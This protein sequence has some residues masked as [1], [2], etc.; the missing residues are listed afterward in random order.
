MASFQKRG[1]SWR[2]IVRKGGA[3]QSATFQTKAAAQA[4]AATTEAGIIAGKSGAIP[5]K[6]FG[7]LLDEY[8]SKVSPTK[9]GCRWEQVRIGLFKRDEIASVKLADLG[10]PHFAAWRDRRLKSVSPAT[11]RREWVLMSG[12]CT[13]AQGMEMAGSSPNGRGE[14]PSRSSAA[15]QAD[16]GPRARYAAAGHGWRLEARDRPNL[17]CVHVRMR[18]GHAC[19]ATGHASTA[20]KKMRV[21]CA[22]ESLYRNAEK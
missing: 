3:A 15:R 13:V 21:E 2:A 17:P 11:V 1:T 7:D 4:W 19:R 10:T 8:A 5:N 16:N 20:K 12:A 9:R 18:N 14:A 6:T 22:T